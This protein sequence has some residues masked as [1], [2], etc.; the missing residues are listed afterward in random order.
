MPIKIKSVP[1]GGLTPPVAVADGGTGATDAATARTNLG[2][3][4]AATKAFGTGA[5]QLVELDAS[6]KLPAVDGSQLT[7]L[8]GGGLWSIVTSEAELVAALAAQDPLIYVGADITATQ[9][10]AVTEDTEIRTGSRY[11]LI[12]GGSYNFVVTTG[13]TLTLS[14]DGRDVSQL[15]WNTSGA[16]HDLVELGSTARLV[17]RD[18][19]I[20]E[21]A[22]SS[23]SG[24]FCQ[25]S[26]HFR[27]ESARF[28]YQNDSYTRSPAA[29]D[30]S[31]VIHI[32]DVELVGSG[33]STYQKWNMTT[34][35][36]GTVRNLRLLGVWSLSFKAV[37]IKFSISYTGLIENV[38]D[39][40]NS[41]ISELQARSVVNCRSTGDLYVSCYEGR[42]LYAGNNLI[43]GATF[44]RT[45]TNIESATINASAITP[46]SSRGVT[47]VGVSCSVFT[48]P[49]SGAFKI[50]GG[51]LGSSIT[52]G[53]N[54]DR[55]GLESVSV[56]D[57][58]TT[59]GSAT[60][61]IAAGATDCIINGCWTDAAISDSGTGTQFGPN[62]VY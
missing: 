33:T 23:N 45:L 30:S 4:T 6:A 55:S 17:I 21:S 50:V 32:Q 48:P 44:T 9:D 34:L 14:G 57:I 58:S 59:G 60:I 49:S 39:I 11:T 18:L 29:V 26:R 62:V 41:W 42:G 28:T 52:I 15:S 5:N 12:M 10:Y 2:L 43:F 13:Y 54:N 53:A 20:V 36:S 24:G 56:G 27:I 16:A 47:F 22:S 8:P 37:I 31:A 35:Y 1:S 51:A 38:G 46:V 25:T 3:G 19:H 40:N 61:T 7:N